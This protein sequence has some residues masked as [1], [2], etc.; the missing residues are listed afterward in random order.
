MC[1]T[2]SLRNCPRTEMDR[3]CKDSELAAARTILCQFAI[4]A[5]ELLTAALVLRNLQNYTFTFWAFRRRTFV[6]GG[7]QTIFL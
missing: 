4:S 2:G 5:T 6:G 3:Y 7:R 1:D